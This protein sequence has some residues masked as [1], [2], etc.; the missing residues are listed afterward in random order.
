MTLGNSRYRQPQ[1]PV[2]LRSTISRE[3]SPLGRC[4]SASRHHTAKAEE[5]RLPSQRQHSTPRASCFACGH[6]AASSHD[7]VAGRFLCSGVI[8]FSPVFA[9]S[10]RS[11]RWLEA[12]NGQRNPIVPLSRSV[13]GAVFH[14][15]RNQGLAPETMRWQALLVA[16][17]LPHC[18]AAFTPVAPP[19]FA[20]DG[21]VL[22]AASQQGKAIRRS[23]L[24]T[25]TDSQIRRITRLDSMPGWM[26]KRDGMAY[27]FPGAESLAGEPTE[28][29]LELVSSFWQ[30]YRLEGA[31]SVFPLRMPFVC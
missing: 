14:L 30:R 20:L 7:A 29:Y 5:P 18:G 27:Y 11:C 15:A 26:D 25:F 1:R 9:A 12:T 31:M 23:P 8:V 28:R 4:A 13:E 17:A 16:A 19:A 6:D 21:Q 22:A 10:R 2:R 24:I 3:E